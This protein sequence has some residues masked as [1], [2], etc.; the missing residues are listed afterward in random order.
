MH[1]E[2]GNIL[3]YAIGDKKFAYFNTSEPER[4][5]FS[6]RVTSERLVEL[7]GI[8]GIKPARYMGRFHW[9][10]IVQPLAIP[11]D[12]LR[13]LVS[14]SYQRAAD[15]LGKARRAALANAGAR[16]VDG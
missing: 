14:W 15:S 13:E 5:R 9:V 3:V 10:T 12:Y 11:E 4:W 2:P 6:I 1:E 7:T 8:A 16:S